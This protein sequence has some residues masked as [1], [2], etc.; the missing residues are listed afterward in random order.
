MSYRVLSR[1]R[2]ELMG[3]AMLWVM[4]FHAYD[5]ELGNGLMNAVRAAGFG[6]VDIFILLSALGLAMSQ[7]RQSTEYAAFLRRRAGRLLPAYFAVMI[8]YTLY[9]ILRAQ[10][11]WIALFWN[12]TPLYYWVR[13]PGAFNWYVA[14]ILVFYALTP[15]CLSAL[16]RA[17]RRE[18]LAISA[19][20]GGCSCVSG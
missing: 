18:L 10:A 6:G 14:G 12:S 13:C 7:T 1:Y 2:T 16:C 9:L 5:L 15:P 20:T 11:P 3:V 17:R 8:P 19:V 4:C